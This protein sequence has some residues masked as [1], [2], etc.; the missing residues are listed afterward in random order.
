MRALLLI[1]SLLLLPASSLAQLMPE[2]VLDVYR[3]SDLNFSPDGRWVAFG[4]TAPVEGTD[5]NQ[6]LW[7]LDVASQK[8][9]QFTF[10][11][12][13][14][15]Q[16]RWNPQG[17]ALAF[18]SNRDGPTQIYL[19]SM[20]GGEAA[21]LTEGKSGIRSFAWSPDGT[22]MAY[23]ASDPPS[24]EEEQE[25]KDRGDAEVVNANEHL[26]RLWILDVES[27]EVTAITAAEWAISSMEWFPS[28][29]R[30]AVVATDN[31]DP[32]HDTDRIFS[33]SAAGGEMAEISAP[34]GPFGRV[35]ISP[36]GMLLSY[37]ASRVD[38]PTTHDLYLQP[39]N[40]GPA[41]NLTA[42]TLDRPVGSYV[43]IDDGSLFGLVNNGFRTEFYRITTEGRAEP[44][45]LPG[46][47]GNPSA[48]ALGESGAV[49]YVEETATRIS[50]LWLSDG[51][52]P[53]QQ[54]SQF[55]EAW[56]TIPLLQPEFFHYPSFDGTQIEGA[57]VK[58]AGYAGGPIP[59]IVL[60]HGG[61]TGRRRDVFEPWGQMLASRGY[62]VF[63]PN[64]RG[65]VGYGWAFLESNR[66]DWGGGDFKDVMAGVD[67]LV[68]E[69]VADEDRLG[70]VSGTEPSSGP[71]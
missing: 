47:T 17:G 19:L 71:S 20:Q 62:A 43:W 42:S 58:P 3:I 55:N 46:Q 25:K 65:S 31:P 68:H 15:S 29:G 49:A 28:G 52:R 16:P 35:S 13:S 56:D 9:R 4:V 38:G 21:P 27:K 44:S 23:L 12:K 14:E 61:P 54:V 2:Q 39:L 60:I 32:D 51:N 11:P 67:F 63:Y 45:A 7:V 1:L 70:R 5:R 37:L 8:V 24:D 66:A 69:G 10:S 53:P 36:D 33:V 48:F 64:I 40:G 22:R 57:L 34:V 59:L 26:T 30:L 18:L 41:R 6:D 50:E